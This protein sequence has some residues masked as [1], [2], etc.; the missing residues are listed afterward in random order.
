MS[1]TNFCVICLY[2]PLL[3]S[4]FMN[5]LHRMFTLKKIPIFLYFS[6]Y[7]SIRIYNVI[8]S[9][10]TG[11]DILLY[12]ENMKWESY[13]WD[14]NSSWQQ[15]TNI[16]F[17]MLPS[18]T[19]EILATACLWPGE[20]THLHGSFKQ[21]SRWDKLFVMSIN[22]PETF[23]FSILV[24]ETVQYYECWTRNSH[25]RLPR[26]MHRPQIFSQG[27]CLS[28]NLTYPECRQ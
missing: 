10:S 19:Q 23:R 5:C 9:R 14:A 18:W 16:S 7:R 22:G 11:L 15:A 6:M 27:F 17:G 25:T 21:A 12:Q 26:D 3:Y 1:T 4:D 8:W 13:S 20:P 24:A 28:L 2:K